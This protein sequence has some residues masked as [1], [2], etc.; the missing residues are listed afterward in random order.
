MTARGRYCSHIAGILEIQV[1]QKNHHGDLLLSLIIT[2]LRGLQLSKY[3][4]VPFRI[5]AEQYNRGINAKG[6]CNSW[7]TTRPKET[8]KVYY[9]HAV[10]TYEVATPTSSTSVEQYSKL[11]QLREVL[12]RS[13][14]LRKLEIKF[15]YSWFDRNVKW[16]GFIARPHV[17]NL[18]LQTS[19]K[20][21]PLQELTFC[22]PPETYE[23]T[24]EHGCGKTA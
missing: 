11:P 13:P 5:G 17:L 4:M 19:D 6:L 9:G 21:P 12:L 23:F 16:S 15:E 14:N 18:P 7:K 1:L 3:K 24:L 8:S 10:G 22:S 20:L 2:G